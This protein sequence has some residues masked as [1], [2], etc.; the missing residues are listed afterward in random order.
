M[1]GIEINIELQNN[2]NKVS[3]WSLCYKNILCLNDDK[4][5]VIIPLIDDRNPVDS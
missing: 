4:C 2:I 5:F 1:K 3:V